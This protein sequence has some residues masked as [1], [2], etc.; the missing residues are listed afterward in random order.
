VTAG[1]RRFSPLNAP[2]GV[3][4]VLMLIA[5][6]LVSQAVALVVVLLVPPPYPPMYRLDEVAAALE[7]GPLRLHDGRVLRLS[8]SQQ[9]PAPLRGAGPREDLE[10]ALAERLQTDPARVRLSVEHHGPQPRFGL[11]GVEP[12][13]PHHRPGFDHM[14]GP[15]P[16]PGL[17]REPGR[18]P[19]PGPNEADPHGPDAHDPGPPP[20]GERERFG[21]RRADMIFGAFA[22]SWRAPS[23]EWRT[24]S[25]EPAPF[26]SG[27][28]RDVTLWFLGCVAVMA[29][30]GYLFARRLTA[31]IRRFAGAPPG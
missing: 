18:G 11:A 19:G 28:R 8:R 16:P 10:L 13:H 4:A 22:A 24:V 21:G 26:F 14:P 27:W 5:G 23:G 1:R 12:P 30:V 15:P 17:G 20:P 31:P 7:G 29:P 6:L 9:A 3:Q 2:T 25:A